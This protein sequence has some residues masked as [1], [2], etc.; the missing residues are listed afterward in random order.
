MNSS[1]NTSNQPAGRKQ[2]F[3]TVPRILLS[4]AVLGIAAAFTV[5]SCN[6]VAPVNST[7]STNTNQSAPPK[8]NSMAAPPSVA[9]PTGLRDAKLTT[10]DGSSLKLS[11]YSDKVVIVNLWATWCGPCRIE[12]PELVKLSKE[13]KTRGLE[14]IGLTTQQ[15]DPSMENVRNFV[16][17]QNVDYHIV[18]DDGSFAA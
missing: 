10:V 14:V 8:A 4:I 7:A 5:S 3:W 16:R 13:Y 18:W 2:G 15:N 12:M 17:S 1:D 9:L 6:S 11:D